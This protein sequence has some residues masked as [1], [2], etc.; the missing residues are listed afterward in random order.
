MSELSIKNHYYVSTRERPDF[1]CAYYSLTNDVSIVST[2]QL[3]ASIRL[4]LNQSRDL[5][6]NFSSHPVIFVRTNA[7]KTHY[8][9]LS[10]SCITG[11]AKELQGYLE[12][13]DYIT[14]ALVVVLLWR[15]HFPVRLCVP[16]TR[17]VTFKLPLHSVVAFVWATI[18]AYDFE[19]FFSFFFFLIGWVFLATLEFKRN[20]PSFWRQ[21]RSYSELLMILIFSKSFIR[22]QTVESNEN[23]E[24]SF[25]A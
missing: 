22:P 3:L 24:E 20:H 19:K 21:P 18:L 6:L 10:V 4:L 25:V 8:K 9:A 13:L 15:G 5:D 14:D 23:I 17:P 7:T 2:S 11:Y 12:I 16:F 1:K